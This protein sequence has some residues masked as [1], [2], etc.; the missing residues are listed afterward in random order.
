MEESSKASKE[1][2][3]FMHSV[4]RRLS[5]RSIVSLILVAFLGVTIIFIFAIRNG[6]KI[7]FWGIKIEGISQDTPTSNDKES[8]SQ[9]NAPSIPSVSAS[10]LSLIS[11]KH[12][13]AQLRKDDLITRIKVLVKN[14]EEL[15]ELKKNISF[16]LLE[17]EI[18]IIPKLGN[19]KFI[20]TRIDDNSND[21]KEAY[22]KIQSVLKD[23]GSYDGPIDGNQQATYNALKEFQ[24][25]WNKEERKEV[26]P[27]LDFGIFGNVT[28]GAIRRIVIAK[29]QRF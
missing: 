10:E 6:A 23:I 12:F 15:E 19:G 29:E 4:L 25:A 24:S 8:T 18:R 26:F 13:G 9:E 28:L 27:P 11:D 3:G 14:S 16:K 7:N 5:T 21:T 1:D 17:L 2:S 22:K 20:D